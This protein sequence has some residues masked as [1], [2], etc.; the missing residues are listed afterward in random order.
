MVFQPRHPTQTRQAT[1]RPSTSEGGWRAQPCRQPGVAALRRPHRRPG[2][3]GAG[4]RSMEEYSPAVALAGTVYPAMQANMRSRPSMHALRLRN[5]HSVPA[6]DKR[7]AFGELDEI[8]QRA[9]VQLQQQAR[10]VSADGLVADKHLLGYL[11][12][13]ITL[14]RYCNTDT[15][16]SDRRSEQF[17][18]RRN[19][20]LLH[21]THG[22][23]GK[24]TV[25][26][27][28]PHSPPSPVRPVRPGLL[29]TETRWRP[30]ACCAGRRARRSGRS[31]R[32]SSG[33][34]PAPSGG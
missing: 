31:G 22:R 16:R 32:G 3:S 8:H 9:G 30:P 4:I 2:R 21:R 18:H 29:Q 7:I 25:S 1:S 10:L 12:V 23:A 34:T 17:L 24:V 14:L 11:L 6:L 26:P 5:P 19:R 27:R 13:R 15:S 28:R 20:R 33:A